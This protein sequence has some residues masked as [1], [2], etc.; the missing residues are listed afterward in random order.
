MAT[1]IDVLPFGRKVDGFA[2]EKAA[3]DALYGSP[4]SVFPFGRQY[5][6]VDKQARTTHRATA[7]TLMTH[8]CRKRSRLPCLSLGCTGESAHLNSSR[9]S[10]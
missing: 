4:P 6:W 5:T 1:S 8:R 7:S 10:S 9:M 2:R 3:M